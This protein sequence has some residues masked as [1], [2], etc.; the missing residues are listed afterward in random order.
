[1]EEPI[2]QKDGGAPGEI[3]VSLVG[4]AR[5]G[6][7]VSSRVEQTGGGV[8]A[9]AREE[10]TRETD[11]PDQ[12]R[13]QLGSGQDLESGVRSRMERGFGHDFNNVRVHTDARAAQLSA[14]LDARA[15]TIGSDVGFGAGEYRPGTLIG[16]ALIAHELAHVIQ[17]GDQASSSAPILNNGNGQV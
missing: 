4:V 2:T 12:I 1:P 13:S 3:A 6:P 15:F 7:E 16:D 9:K 11:D 17:Q 8:L 5:V 14:R 10:G